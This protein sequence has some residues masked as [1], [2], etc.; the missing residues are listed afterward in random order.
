MKK[1]KHFMTLGFVRIFYG[2]AHIINDKP[3]YMN[4]ARPTFYDMYC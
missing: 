1:N 3:L 2:E 4:I